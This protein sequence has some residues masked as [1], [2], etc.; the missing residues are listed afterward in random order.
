MKN[1]SLKTKDSSITIWEEHRPPEWKASS[2][3]CP[4]KFTTN[5]QNIRHK[6][7]LTN[8]LIPSYFQRFLKP[9]PSEY[10]SL[11][12]SQIMSRQPIIYQWKNMNDINGLAVIYFNIFNLNVNT[13]RLGTQSMNSNL[14][15]IATLFKCP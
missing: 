9:L 1:M 14:R 12:V 13:N 4:L 3:T 10:I 2:R 11:P 15:K 5:T 7:Y 6:P 8:K